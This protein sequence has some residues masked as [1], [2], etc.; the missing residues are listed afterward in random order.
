MQEF[1]IQQ[2]KNSINSELFYEVK[3]FSQL[4]NEVCVV[5]LP[6]VFGDNRFK[7]NPQNSE[8]LQNGGKK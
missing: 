6:G 5:Q 2:H 3:K 8:S 1:D 7:K 4:K